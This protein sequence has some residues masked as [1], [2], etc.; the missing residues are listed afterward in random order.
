MHGAST[1]PFTVAGLGY[2][3][4]PYWSLHAQNQRARNQRDVGHPVYDSAR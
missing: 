4:G 3:S 2:P 1:E